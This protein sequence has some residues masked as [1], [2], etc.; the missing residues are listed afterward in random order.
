MK[1]AII[2]VKNKRIV[3]Y[4][5]VQVICYLLYLRR[6]DYLRNEKRYLVSIDRNITDYSR[7]RFQLVFLNPLPHNIINGCFKHYS[8]CW[9][10]RFQLIFRIRTFCFP[11]TTKLITTSQISCTIL[12]HRRHLLIWIQTR[13][14]KWE[15]WESSTE[16]WHFNRWSTE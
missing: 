11:T 5:F 12:A 4:V 9:L 13:I 1:L 14:L 8:C 7:K 3:L 6:L 10:L 16:K 15:A 2:P